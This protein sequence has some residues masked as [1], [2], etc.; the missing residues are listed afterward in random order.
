MIGIVESILILTFLEDSQSYGSVH[1][2]FLKEC[3]RNLNYTQEF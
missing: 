2:W 1:E 3:S